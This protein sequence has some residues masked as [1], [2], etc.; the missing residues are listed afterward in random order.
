M[1]VV[2]K[3][4]SINICSTPVLMTQ[5]RSQLSCKY[6]TKSLTS[7]QTLSQ[8]LLLNEE[9]S[10]QPCPKHYSK[11]KS[12][13]PKANHGVYKHSPVSVALAGKVKPFKGPVSL[14]AKLTKT[15]A[16]HPI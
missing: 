15:W 12:Q 8:F 2:D 3:Y 13:Q 7:E 16:C 11:R 9:I 1:L 4:Q 6:F 10:M 14:C 5:L